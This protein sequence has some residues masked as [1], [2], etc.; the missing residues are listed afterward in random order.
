M[1]MTITV[2]SHQLPNIT[3]DN[4][5]FKSAKNQANGSIFMITRPFINNCQEWYIQGEMFFSSY[6][7]G[8]TM[9]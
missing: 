3:A 2:S 4:F 6:F 1:L 8:L 7:Y 9:E 5:L